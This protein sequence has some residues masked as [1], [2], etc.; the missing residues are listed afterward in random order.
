MF[1]HPVTALFIFPGVIGLVLLGRKYRCR[2]QDVHVNSAI[3]GAVFALFGLL[4]AFTF[5]GAISRYDDHRKIV[6]EEA[7]DI[8][9]A[10][11]RLDLLP[12]AAQPELR[13]LFRQYTVVREH[14]FDETPDTQQSIDAA[15]QTD[16]LLATIWRKSLA[17][18]NSP[19]AHIDATKLLVPAL[20]AMIDV[21][22]TRKNAYNMHPPSIIFLL[23][24]F[25]SFGCAFMAG[26]SME[27]GKHV[28]LYTFALAIT[29]TLTVYSTLEVEY[30]RYGFIHLTSQDE[31][32]V[33]LNNSMK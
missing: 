33:D 26:Y 25:F 19:G 2:H 30:P 4:L 24:F 29:V 8:G 11:L 7:N 3:E 12:P 5:S 22:V 32:Y 6:V 16:A 17:A 1:F 9:T 13:Q 31:T 21:T 28:W 14:R 15:N 23:L 27:P 18:A 10:Y 20:N